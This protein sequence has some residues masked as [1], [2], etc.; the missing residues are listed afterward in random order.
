M[1]RVRK[2]PL[3]YVESQKSQTFKVGTTE[4]DKSYSCDVKYAKTRFCFEFQERGVTII[5]PF[6]KRICFG[7]FQEMKLKDKTNSD[8]FTIKTNGKILLAIS[9]FEV[10]RFE[11]FQDGNI[12]KHSSDFNERLLLE[13]LKILNE[14]L[15]DLQ[16]I[17]QDFKI[18]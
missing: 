11:Y 6:E 14:R 3:M 12:I 16:Q 10:V 5:K 15:T 17:Y 2:N 13:F 1:D 4:N 8:V 9:K 18:I 7:P